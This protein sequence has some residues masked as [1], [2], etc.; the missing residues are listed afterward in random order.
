MAAGDTAAALA[1]FVPTLSSDDLRLGFGK[2]DEAADLAFKYG[3]LSFASSTALLAYTGASIGQRAIDR[4][5]GDEYR[6]LNLGGTTTWYLWSTLNKNYV[7]T[8]Q[9]LTVGNGTVTASYKLTDGHLHVKIGVTWGSTSGISGAV[10]GSLPMTVPDTGWVLYSG[11]YAGTSISVPVVMF[12]LTSSSSFRLRYPAISGTTVQGT[13]LTGTAP[14]TWAAGN[15]MLL[16]LQTK[17][18]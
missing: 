5:T 7:P 4:A 8:W 17:A 14:F 18:Y 3:T 1:G 11:H 10:I 15:T 16:N 2:I 6:W 9:G 13:D 12:G